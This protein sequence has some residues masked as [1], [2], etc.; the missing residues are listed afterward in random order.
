ML[1]FVVL[2]LVEV[3]SGRLRQRKGWEGVELGTSTRDK[4]GTQTIAVCNELEWVVPPRELG[5]EEVEL[6][7]EVWYLFLCNKLR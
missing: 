3:R 6:G 5:D 1:S 4:G 2:R 7:L